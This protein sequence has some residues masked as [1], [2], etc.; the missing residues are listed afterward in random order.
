MGEMNEVVAL[1]YLVANKFK[2]SFIGFLETNELPSEI[3][4]KLRKYGVE[5]EEFHGYYLLTA[6]ESLPE[7]DV[8]ILSLLTKHIKGKFAY[9]VAIG[10]N[11]IV[12]PLE[13]MERYKLYL[14]NGYIVPVDAN[15]QPSIQIQDE[16]IRKLIK[17]IQL[18]LS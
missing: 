8:V 9:A 10:K 14:R 15:G 3:E 12:T 18:G 17:E 1:L 6:E 5:V 2:P 4:N 7:V 16:E 13:D 11:Y